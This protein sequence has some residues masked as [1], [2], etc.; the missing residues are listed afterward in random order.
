MYP[1]LTQR[2]QPHLPHCPPTAHTVDDYLVVGLSSSR[3][4]TTGGRDYVSSAWFLFSNFAK[5]NKRERDEE[6]PDYIMRDQV[7]VAKR[8]M[9]NQGLKEWQE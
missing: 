2:L 5:R 1:T 4:A 8:L 7:G 6:F 3:P 9:E